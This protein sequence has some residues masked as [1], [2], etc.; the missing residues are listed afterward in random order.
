MKLL[1]ISINFSINCASIRDFR[2]AGKN[3]IYI[4][5]IDHGVLYEVEDPLIN[6][7]ELYNEI[8]IF[9]NCGKNNFYSIP[10][11]IGRQTLM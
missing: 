2:T 10:E 6:S 1:E 5:S 11:Y 7:E 3:I 8:I 4:F 9:L